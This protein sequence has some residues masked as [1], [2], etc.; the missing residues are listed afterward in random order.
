MKQSYYLTD[1]TDRVRPLVIVSQY[2]TNRTIQFNLNDTPTSAKVI[3]GTE[4]IVPTINGSAVSFL[5]PT[6]LTDTAQKLKGEVIIGDRMGTVNFDFVVDAT[7][8]VESP[9]DLSGNRALSILLGR[10]V[11]VDNPRDALNL[12]MKG[13]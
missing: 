5:V 11:N 4:E 7:P 13:E 9:V 12:I 3:I 2:D 6:S 10:N 1:I 8:S